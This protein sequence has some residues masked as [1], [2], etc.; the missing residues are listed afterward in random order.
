[1]AEPN[2][3][4]GESRFDAV[5]QRESNGRAVALFSLAARQENLGV[6]NENIAISC[7]SVCSSA[8]TLMSRTIH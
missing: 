4:V 2:R 7:R 3:E 6:T 8:N 5:Q 1:M